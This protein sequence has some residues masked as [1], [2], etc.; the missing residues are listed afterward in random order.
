MSK[1]RLQSNTE[2]FLR[3]LLGIFVFASLMLCA[4]AAASYAGGRMLAVLLGSLDN[5]W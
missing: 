1:K 4:L 5:D 2:Q 3:S